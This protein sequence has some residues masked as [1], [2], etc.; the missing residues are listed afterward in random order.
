[1]S[2]DGLLKRAF[3]DDEPEHLGSGWL[4]GCLSVLLGCVSV[5]AVLCFHFPQWL[6][7]TEL[8]AVYPMGVVRAAVQVTIGL[9]F[10][11]GLVSAALRRRKVLGLTGTGLA[12]GASL[13]GGATVPVADGVAARP[14]L[15]L[16][17]FVLNLVLLVV[18]F[19]PLERLFPQW[20][21]QGVFRPGWTTDVL[22]FFVSHL[23]VQASTFLTLAPAHTLFRWAVRPEIQQAVAA[24]PLPLQALEIVLVADFTEYWV[25][26]LFHR[27]GWLWRFHAVHHSSRS[28]DWLAGSRLHLV[29]VVVTRGLTF[30]PLHVLGFATPAV[31]AYLVFV[32]FHAV[33][34]HAN[35]R[36]RFGAL[37]RLLVV[38]RF[39]HWHHAVA[40]IDKNF[41]VHLPW[42]DRL[43]G[44]HHCPPEWP[45]AYGIAG[46]PVPD[47]YLQQWVHPLRRE[48][49]AG[50]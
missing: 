11:L 48:R 26:R 49:G 31:Y 42:I 10:L 41:A 33:F 46:H 13:L 28:M 45:G 2:S 5:L 35:V 18:I 43:F 22:H 38:P 15:G 6:T 14:A 39:H 9:T 24:Q 44:T 40:P 17:W 32:S 36:F 27:V 37:E 21:S 30:V 47:G 20:P 25:H 23:L 19:V 1:V 50:G 34:I 29:D 8:R 12:L 7:M 16:D 4:S 3:G